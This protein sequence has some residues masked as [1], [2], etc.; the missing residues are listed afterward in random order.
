MEN[1]LPVPPVV[2]EVVPAAAPATVSEPPAPTAEQAALI[3]DK[4]ASAGLMSPVEI[5]AA[6]ELFPVSAVA[7]A[8]APEVP[9]A[10]LAAAIA[11]AASPAL[12][13]IPVAGAAAG[14]VT[15]PATAETPAVTVSGAAAGAAA[16]PATGTS[17]VSM[18]EKQEATPSAGLVK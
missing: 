4:L 10:A 6:K 14:T 15:V 16:V 17:F 3:I 1:V 7:T 12:E 2:S 11:G 8:P 5:K 13:N 9:A 18:L